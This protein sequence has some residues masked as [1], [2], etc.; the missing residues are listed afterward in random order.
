MFEP[1]G[2]GGRGR[3][4]KDELRRRADAAGMGEEG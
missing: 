3:A 2:T 4:H 1:R